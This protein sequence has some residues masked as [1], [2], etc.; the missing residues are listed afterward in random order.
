MAQR[1]MAR[2]LLHRQERRPRRAGYNGLHESRSPRFHRPL[3]NVVEQ[4]DVAR[5]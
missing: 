1:E 3:R 5:N 2:L 4:P